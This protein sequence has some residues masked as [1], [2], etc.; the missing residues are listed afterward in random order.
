MYEVKIKG[1]DLVDLLED[2][3]GHVYENIKEEDRITDVQLRYGDE[4][5]ITIGEETE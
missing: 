1:S 2:W 5:V 3:S 4:V